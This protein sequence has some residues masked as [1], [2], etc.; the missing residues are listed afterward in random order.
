MIRKKLAAVSAVAAAALA[1]SACASS[2]DSE[3]TEDYVSGGTFVKALT[4]DPGSIIPFNAI[5]FDTWEVVSTAYE[6]LVYVTPDG[7]FTP[8]LAESWEESPNQVVYTLKDGIT[9]ADGT[10]FTAETAANNINY[11]ANPDNA[12][13][14][15]GATVTE[16]VSAS[17][18]GNVLTVTTSANDP[19]LLANTGTIL[20][21]C[22]AGID[23]P[24]SLA[25]SANGTG[26]FELTDIQAQSSYT[27][28]KR[29]GY[30]WGPDGVTSE[31]VGLPDEIELR[32]VDD[33]STRANLLLAGDIN[34]ASIVGA[35]SARV[36]SA[37]L[38]STGV[39]NSVGE[40]LFNEHDGRVFSDPLV[41]QALTL[42]LDRAEVGAVIADGKALD[43]VSLVTKTPLLCV[44]EPAEWQLPETDLE[45]AGE[46]LDEAGWE[47]GSDGLRTKDGEPLTVKFIYDAPT[48]TH[49]PAA[50]LVKQIWDELGVTTELSANDAAA[51]S[52]QLWSTFDWDTGWIQLA[53]NSPVQLSTFFG[54]TPE[55]GGLNFMFVDN[56]DYTANADKARAA[57]SADEACGYWRAAET[58]LI[59]R[60]DVFPLADNIIPTYMN[61]AVFEAPAYV[62]PTS[63]R[64]LG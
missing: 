37:G 48:A 17:A 27:F 62:M 34:A 54:A 47:L 61:G 25:D 1:L 10:D 30:T 51:W 55:E 26:L 58:A 36:E 46:L 45:K 8:W 3:P 20:Q 32:I 63:I 5:S 59:D 50:E 49:A 11:N 40:M 31:T 41:R 29:E 2:P 56:P 7:E 43:A 60:V 53:P 16:A 24:D 4:G 42:A 9:C 14:Y 21:V 35:D 23:D 6:A 64:M 12:T 44:V 15:Y 19:F 33:E 22:Q 18:E 38:E 13:F 52:D 57:S 28:E 39:R